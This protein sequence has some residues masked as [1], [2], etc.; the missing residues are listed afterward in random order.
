MLINPLILGY[1]FEKVLAAPLYMFFVSPQ[2]NVP[3]KDI[4]GANG[5]KALPH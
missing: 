5:L 4:I 2:F 3:K 1:P